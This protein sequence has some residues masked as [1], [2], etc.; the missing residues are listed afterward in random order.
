MELTDTGI[1]I[2]GR[3]ERQADAVN[4]ERRGQPP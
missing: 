2:R 4:L 3:H 1:Q